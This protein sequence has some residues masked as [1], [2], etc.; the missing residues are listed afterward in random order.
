MSI[1]PYTRKPAVIAR[2]TGL[3]ENAAR[4]LAQSFNVRVIV[5]LLAHMPLA[6]AME[7]AWPLA[8]AHAVLATLLGL[9]WAWLGRTRRVLYSLSYIAGCEVLWRMTE[10]RVFWEYGKYALALVA[11]VALIAE[12]RRNSGKL[13]TVMPVLLLLAALPAVALALL[14]FSLGEAFDQLSF[15]LSAYIALGIAAL[16]FWERP[17]DRPTAGRLLLMLMAP[18]VGV[19][20][21]ASFSTV[22]QMAV[23]SFSAASSWIRSGDFGA[24]QVANTLSLGSLAGIILLVIL[25]RARSARIVIALLTIGMVVQ[26]ILT[27][28]RGGL[29]SFILA[30]VAFGMHLLRTPG[31]RSRFVLMVALFVAMVFGLIYPWLDDMSTGAVTARFQDLDTTGRLELAQADMMAFQDNPVVGAGVGGSILYHEYVLGD[32]VSAHTEYTRLLAEHGAF[33]VLIIGLMLW[34]LLKRYLG[35]EPG[36]ARAISASMAVWMLSVMVHSATRMVAVPFALVLALIAWQMAPE[37]RGETPAAG[38]L[39]GGRVVVPPRSQ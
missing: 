7:S 29:Y 27:F 38:P 12:W 25:P 34:M 33:G 21:L 13:R 26:S 36:L 24:N 22:T 39:P 20:F 6:Y 10:A 32:D 14:E 37:D 18:A 16:Y 5:F 1:T 3:P 30:G 8:T 19:L 35:N 2:A 31:A 4:E 28:S 11:L 17:V 9:R 15:N 23:D